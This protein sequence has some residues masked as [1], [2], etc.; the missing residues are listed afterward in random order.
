MRLSACFLSCLLSNPQTAAALRRNTRPS[1]HDSALLVYGQET[2]RPI[3]LSHYRTGKVSF[4][5]ST[6][7]KT[8]T[9]FYNWINALKDLGTNMTMFNDFRRLKFLLSLSKNRQIPVPVFC[10]PRL[11]YCLMFAFLLTQT[12]EE[13][14]FHGQKRFFSLAGQPREIQASQ[15]RIRCI[16]PARE[17][18]RIT[19]SLIK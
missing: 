11:S 9:K 18:S 12:R 1:T 3:P 8:T 2:V 13:G 10:L 6:P 16:L 5:L 7:V 4:F 15:D 17:F 19:E 14:L